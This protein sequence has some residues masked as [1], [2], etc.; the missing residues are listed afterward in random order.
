MVR[1]AFNHVIT[2]VYIQPLINLQVA[3]GQKGLKSIKK[4]AMKRSKEGVKVDFLS[5]VC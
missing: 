1:L 2:V 5:A 3:E 4:R